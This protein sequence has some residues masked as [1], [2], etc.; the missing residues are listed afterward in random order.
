MQNLIW[1]FPNNLEN[2][3]LV[4]YPL[5]MNTMWRDPPKMQVVHAVLE[6]IGLIKDVHYTEMHEWMAVHRGIVFLDKQSF[7]IAKMILT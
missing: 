3:V 6:S 1:K 2:Q 5:D 7:C 4:C